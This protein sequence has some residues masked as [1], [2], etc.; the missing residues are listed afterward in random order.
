MLQHVNVEQLSHDWLHYFLMMMHPLLR[1]SEQHAYCDNDHE[2]SKNCRSSA[3]SYTVRY[4]VDLFPSF[5]P[6]DCNL[7]KRFRYQFRLEVV[8]SYIISQSRSKILLNGSRTIKNHLVSQVR[9]RCTLWAVSG[10]II[11]SRTPAH[12]NLL[13]AGRI[14]CKRG[15]LSSLS[16]CQL[17]VLLG[18]S[19]CFALIVVCRCCCR[20]QYAMNQSAFFFRIGAMTLYKFI[21]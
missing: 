3:M 19:I 4:E 20:V 14:L 8:T 18:R 5:L 9:Y 16:P 2:E 7:C 13:R 11:T 21:D 15:N 10:Y 6:Q 12:N 17:L 1:T